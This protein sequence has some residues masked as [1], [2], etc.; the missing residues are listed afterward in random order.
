MP[1]CKR[2]LTNLDWFILSG[3]NLGEPDLDWL[4]KFYLESVENCY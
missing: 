1:L 2:G 3:V 4:G